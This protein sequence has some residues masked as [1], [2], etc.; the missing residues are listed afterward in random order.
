MKKQLPGIYVNS[1]NKKID[2]NKKIHFID[3]DIVSNNEFEQGNT[4]ESRNINKYATPLPVK[5]KEDKIV[6]KPNII[7]INKKV[8]SVFSSYKFVYKAKCS[9]TYKDSTIEK[10]IISRKDNYLLTLDNERINIDDI[11][12]IS[13]I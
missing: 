8:N 7:E 5:K 6:E 11:Y 1:P 3:N 9:V 4:N 13:I 12:D 2:N 10:T